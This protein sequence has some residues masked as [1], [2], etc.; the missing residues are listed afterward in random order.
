MRGT[1]LVLGGVAL[2]AALVIVAVL[3]VRDTVSTGPATTSIECHDAAVDLTIGTIPNAQ[4]VFVQVIVTDED[5]RGWVVQW[6]NARTD[7]PSS[8]LE[9]LGGRVRHG[10]RIL[11][12]T[13][14]GS[15]RTVRVRPQ[16]TEEWCQVSASLS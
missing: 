12:D 14:D 3:V 13:D 8:L 4:S 10:F 9:A 11:G 16:G 1:W 15:D 6:P 2:F 7:D 5:A